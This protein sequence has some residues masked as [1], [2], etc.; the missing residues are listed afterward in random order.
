MEIRPAFILNSGYFLKN[1]QN[2]SILIW[3]RKYYNK[4]QAQ[5]SSLWIWLQ[6]PWEFLI[7]CGVMRGI[8]F[9]I[10][11]PFNHHVLLLFYVFAIS[12]FSSIECTISNTFR[13]SFIKKLLWTTLPFKH[14]F[15]SIQQLDFPIDPFKIAPNKCVRFIQKSRLLT[16]EVFSS[17]WKL[18]GAISNMRNNTT[19]DKRIKI[20]LI[21]CVAWPHLPF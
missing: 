19:V 16:L 10:Y 8:K 7:A 14:V 2:R 20:T 6:P 21:W 3:R 9:K 18:I 13:C 1:F 12:T 4:I 15:V 11:S 17:L 5:T